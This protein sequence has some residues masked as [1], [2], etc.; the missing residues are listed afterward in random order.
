MRY[1]YSCD[2]A[3]NGSLNPS[4]DTILGSSN[5]GSNDPSNELKSS[6]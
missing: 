1:L 2:E 5:A 3:Y 4:K 6:E